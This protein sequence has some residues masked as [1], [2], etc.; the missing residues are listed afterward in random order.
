MKRGVSELIGTVLIIGFTIVLAALLFAWQT[1]F[2]ETIKGNVDTRTSFEELCLQTDFSI[3]QACG[4]TNVTLLV[5]N[6]GSQ[7]IAGFQILVYDA[8]GKSEVIPSFPYPVVTEHTTETLIVYPT[9]T[10]AMIE[11]IPKIRLQDNTT[12]YC[13]TNQKRSSIEVC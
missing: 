9:L 1:R 4:S 13:N 12:A 5:K 2:F 8:S 11:L 10:P 6:K 7:D 3:L